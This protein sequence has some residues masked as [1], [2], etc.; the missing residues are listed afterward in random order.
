MLSAGLQ[1]EVVR[2]RATLS[3]LDASAARLTRKRGGSVEVSGACV[4][5]VH[6][7]TL[8]ELMALVTE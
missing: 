7:V 1:Q 8:H 4:H 5:C 2:L 6:N 3:D